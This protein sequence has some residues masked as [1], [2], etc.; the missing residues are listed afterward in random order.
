MV[1]DGTG[2]RCILASHP[3]IN[4]LVRSSKEERIRS[5][6]Q[7]WSINLC[8]Y[9]RSNSIR[10]VNNRMWHL[11]RSNQ[12]SDS[13][14]EDR[15]FH[16]H[17][18][19]PLRQLYNSSYIVALVLLGRVGWDV[20]KYL[21]RLSEDLAIH[22]VHSMHRHD[23]DYT[24]AISIWMAGYRLI[25]SPHNTD[26][27]NSVILRCL[28]N[29]SLL[30]RL[31]EDAFHRSL[32]WMGRLWVR[33]NPTRVYW[34]NLEERIRARW[35]WCRGLLMTSTWFYY[36][37]IRNTQSNILHSSWLSLSI[38][39]CALASLNVFFVRLIVFSTRRLAS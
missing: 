19:F 12:R 10:P 5:R 32:V 39:S 33:R 18:R 37:R 36:I 7:D 17:A 16:E 13:W 25:K 23:M 27:C 2:F 38:F 14:L 30:V 11:H 21:V 22:F 20:L 4:S 31:E 6:L 26:R 9:S 29:N 8:H 34:H 15:C 1:H 28:R 24:C 35:R 3:P